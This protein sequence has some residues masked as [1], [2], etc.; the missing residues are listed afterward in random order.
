V[1]IDVTLAPEHEEIRARVRA[2]VNEAGSP[3]EVFIGG[4]P[5]P[6]EQ[7]DRA[8]APSSQRRTGPVWNSGRRTIPRSSTARTACARVVTSSLR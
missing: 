3:S 5:D 6:A 1:T 7:P 2:F 4:V 8:H